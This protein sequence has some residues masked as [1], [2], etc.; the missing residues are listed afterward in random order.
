[1]IPVLGIL[2][3]IDDCENNC[4]KQGF[5]MEPYTAFTDFKHNVP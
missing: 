4:L 5:E 2:K 3:M 1:M